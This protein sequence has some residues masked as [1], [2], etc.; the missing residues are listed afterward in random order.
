[1]ENGE[2]RDERGLQERYEPHQNVVK[3]E[4]R[5]KAYSNQGQKRD[6]RVLYEVTDTGCIFMSTVDVIFDPVYKSQLPLRQ[7]CVTR[8]SSQ[9]PFF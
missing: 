5:P 6:A 1:M 7:T 2:D 8:G 9:P 3:V 4:G